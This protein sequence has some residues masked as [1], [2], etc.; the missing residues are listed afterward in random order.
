MKCSRLLNTHLSARKPLP[1]Q[2]HTLTR[3]HDLLVPITNC[4][5]STAVFSCARRPASTALRVDRYYRP[6]P[7]GGA[8][9]WAAPT[10]VAGSLTDDRANAMAAVGGA[11]VST[12]NGMWWWSVLAT[13]VD[14]TVPSG[15]PLGISELWPSAG[16]EVQA[17]K[18]YMHEHTCDSVL[19]P[20]LD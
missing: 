14:G 3:T 1:T 7:L 20:L 12:A 8:E 11:G 10:G 15:Q 17:T 19:I 9:I 13:N 2:A 18:A 4:T 5:T 16:G 6:S